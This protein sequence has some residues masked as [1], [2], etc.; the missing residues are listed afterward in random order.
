MAISRPD[1]LRM[2]IFV[3]DPL[4]LAADGATEAALPLTR[5]LL[6]AVVAGFPLAWK[7]SD[8]GTSF[9]WIGAKISLETDSVSVSIPEE[10]ITRYL[11]GL[12]Y[13]KSTCPLLL[14][15]LRSL[16]GKLAFAASIVPRIRPFTNSLWRAAAD[17]QETGRLFSRRKQLN[18]VS[19][20]HLTLP[21][22]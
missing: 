4:Y 11:E 8:G 22:T 18:P 5:A 15:P 3:D 10:K 7:K 17:C 16:A 14:K 12:K 6:W 1:P 19:Y 9:T 13:V 21:T 20:T 2:H